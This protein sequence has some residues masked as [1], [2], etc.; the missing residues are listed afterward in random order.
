[1]SAFTKRFAPLALA[2]AALLAACS[3]DSSSPG[4]EGEGRVV[5]R[6]TDAPFLVDSLRSVNIHVVRVEARVAAADSTA[7]DSDVDN[8]SKGGWQTIA[9]P[10]ATIDV[11]TLRNGA[12]TT[13]GETTLDAGTYSGLRFII[14]PSRSTVTLKDGTTLSG[15]NGGIKFPSANRS[16]IKVNLSE[17]LRVVGGSTTTLLVDFDVNES[18]VLRGNSLKNNGLLFKPV[19]KATIIDA[20]TVNATVRLVN[21]T[22][23]P[24]NFLRNGTALAGSS[25]I[26]FGASSS[27]SS[28]T[29]AAPSLSVTQGTSTTALPGF[30]PSLTAG[31]SYTIIAYPSATGVQFATLGN[32]YTPT[33]GQT[34]FRV[35]NATGSATGY[36]VFVTTVG[37]AL[38]TPTVTNTLAGTASSYV[39]I[40][41]G[42]SLV[43]V[44]SAG[45]TTSLVSIPSQAFAAGQNATLVIAPPAA[46][47]TTPQI[48]VVQGC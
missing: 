28:V 16:G 12:A 19:V 39:S 46:G 5:V 4:A 8:G 24:L 3:D 48:F 2:A 37:G 27:C 11:L 17:P 23:Q 9:T 38:T 47:S 35:F 41:A 30:A 15:A 44:T 18:F 14:D 29:A 45:G 32:A 40:P 6:L 7:A 43:A 33:A 20:A 13:I 36:D 34:G 31:T 1:M 42:T 26:A 10:D 21:A 25:N 22:G